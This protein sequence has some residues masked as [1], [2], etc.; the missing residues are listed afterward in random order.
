MFGLKPNEEVEPLTTCKICGLNYDSELSEDRAEHRKFHAKT[1][2]ALRPRPL[3]RFRRL[4]NATGDP[5]EVK[6]GSGQWRHDEIYLRA[7]MFK[8]EFGYDFPQWSP[9]GDETPDARG[10]LFN[11]DTG[12]FGH[13][14]I[15]GAC[16][17]RWREFA[18]SA[19]RWAMDWV[20]LAPDVRRKGL[21]SRQW[22]LF[23]ERF[24]SFYLQPPVSPA[25]QQFAIKHG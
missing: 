22:A 23:Q 5:V 11:D 3:A 13:G 10:F 24:G 21:L 15:A 9:F 7:K 18:D 6:L 12:T 16:A 4:L 2:R 19:P 8:R 17:F 1:M 14:A 20:W 25:M